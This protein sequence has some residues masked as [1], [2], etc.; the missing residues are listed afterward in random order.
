MSIFNLFGIIKC[1][2]TLRF[3]YS[4]TCASGHLRLN[5]FDRF[6][7]IPLSLYHHCST[8]RHLAKMLAVPGCNILSIFQVGTA[9]QIYFSCNRVFFE[10]HMNKHMRR[11]VFTNKLKKKEFLALLNT[12]L[13]LVVVLKTKASDFKIFRTM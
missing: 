8:A 9:L 13:R 5:S 6:D 11:F 12:Y 7:Y 2:R 4:Q 1:N 10:I 3:G